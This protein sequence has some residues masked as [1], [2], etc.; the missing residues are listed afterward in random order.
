MNLDACYARLNLDPGASLDE[1]KTAFRKR[2]FDL[3]P[4]LHPEDPKASLRFQELNEAYVTLLH[5]LRHGTASQAA[6]RGKARSRKASREYSRQQS[7]RSGRA[8]R[9]ATQ[10]QGPAGDDAAGSEAESGFRQEEILKNI[11]NDPF[12]RQVFEDIFRAV[13]RRKPEQS[14]PRGEHEPKWLRLPW[15][16]QGPG[17]DASRFTWSGLK[18]WLRSQLDH[19][20]TVRLDPARM[21]PGTSLSFQIARIGGKPQTISTTIPPDYQPGRPLRLK[22]LGRKL[23]PFAGDLYLRLLPK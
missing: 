3:H 7:A 9:T 4:D 22:G 18:L 16:R 5:H 23:G 6:A 15:S 12:A 19:E 13:K 10:R 8:E 20:H 17:L 21:L 14:K 11:L 1:V 2:A